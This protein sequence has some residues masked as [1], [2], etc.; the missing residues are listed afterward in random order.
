MLQKSL[1]Q[2][3]K[4]KL[5]AGSHYVAPAG[6]EL[7][8]SLLPRPLGWPARA[9]AAVTR[10][11]R[12]GRAWPSLPGPAPAAG[13]T[14]PCDGRDCIRCPCGPRRFCPWPRPGRPLPRPRGPD[15]SPARALW[16]RGRPRRLC[17]A[18]R[19]S[20]ETGS[21]AQ[22]RPLT[23]WS[24]DADGRAP[25]EPRALALPAPV[26]VQ[27]AQQVLDATPQLA[28][29]QPGLGVGASGLGQRQRVPGRRPRHEQEQ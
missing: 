25:G 28:G 19:G 7:M 29:V 24:E 3:E 27:P 9:A 1:S 16:L 26:G 22:V 15:P 12:L 11:T 13:A 2:K 6:S 20:G 4:F 17:R 21:A 10:E 14:L 23:F 5:G 8:A 18:R